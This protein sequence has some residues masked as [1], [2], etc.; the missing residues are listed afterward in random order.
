[1]NNKIRRSILY[2]AVNIL[3]IISIT[4]FFLPS[5]WVDHVFF[6]VMLSICVIASYEIM[7]SLLRKPDQK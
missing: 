2:T 5:E 6:I 4:M 1:M 7:H 3:L